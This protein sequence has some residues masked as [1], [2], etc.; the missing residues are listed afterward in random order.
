MA[1]ATTLPGAHEQRRDR[2]HRPA[3]QPRVAHIRKHALRL[4]PREGRR[5]RDHDAPPLDGAPPPHHRLTAAC[6]RRRVGSWK[7]NRSRGILWAK[8]RRGPQQNKRVWCSTFQPAT[9]VVAHSSGVCTDA[10][11][12]GQVPPPSEASTIIMTALT[13]NPPSSPPG[14]LVNGCQHTCTAWQRGGVAVDR[15]SGGP[16]SARRATAA[17]DGGAAATIGGDTAGGATGAS[18]GGGG[19]LAGGG[20]GGSSS[21]HSTG[22]TGG[23]TGT[24]LSAA[25]ATTAL[26]AC[27][28]RDDLVTRDTVSSG[29]IDVA[30]RVR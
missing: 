28:V 19:A 11:F 16:C 12:M 26:Q 14:R 25:A 24:G 17:V 20:G 21:A 4:L 8:N 22:S 10:G 7:K 9:W 29:A 13:P 3:T 23:G 18:A 5:Q 6:T 30:S 15:R 1:A 27:R 2:I